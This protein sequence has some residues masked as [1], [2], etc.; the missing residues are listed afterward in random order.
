MN[1]FILN[2]LAGGDHPGR[3]MD[4]PV[5]VFGITGCGGPPVKPAHAPKLR[6]QVFALAAESLYAT[7]EPTLLAEHARREGRGGRRAARLRIVAERRL[8][9]LPL[10][11]DIFPSNGW[12]D[13]SLM[14]PPILAI[15]FSS[16]AR[17]Q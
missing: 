7:S 2:L 15:Y 12:M 10:R 1:R 4:A 8:F 5:A 14:S 16:M 17:T 3:G 6:E 9:P 13:R 11:A